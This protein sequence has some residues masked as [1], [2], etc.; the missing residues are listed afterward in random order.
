[1]R[2]GVPQTA[3]DAR[4]T[5]GKLTRF[6][7]AWTP[8]HVDYLGRPAPNQCWLAFLCLLVQC[9]LPPPRSGILPA[10]PPAILPPA[11][12]ARLARCGPPVAPPAARLHFPPSS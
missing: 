9:W 2:R 5:E 7:A 8:E 1:M 3:L 6:V 12:L 4:I 10:L 11:A